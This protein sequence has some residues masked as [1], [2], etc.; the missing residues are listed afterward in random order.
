MF[1]TKLRLSLS[2]HAGAQPD[3][4]GLKFFRLTLRK[5]RSKAQL[6]GKVLKFWMVFKEEKSL[7]ILELEISQNFGDLKKKVD[8]LDGSDDFE[9][10]EGSN[11]RKGSSKTHRKKVYNS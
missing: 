6:R 11:A 7:A 3:L 2:L 9:L 1:A 4:K 5:K 10:S 8:R